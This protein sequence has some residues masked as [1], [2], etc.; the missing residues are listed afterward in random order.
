MKNEE[1]VMF[2]CRENGET[3]DKGPKRVDGRERENEARE[4]EAG[5]EEVSEESRES[6][7]EGRIVVESKSG[8]FVLRSFGYGFQRR[9]RSEAPGSRERDKNGRRF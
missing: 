3:K 8:D 7:G 5:V 2:G 4:V 1:S 9:R 6:S